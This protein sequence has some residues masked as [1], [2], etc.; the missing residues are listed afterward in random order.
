MALP[1][2]SLRTF[3]SARE[4]DEVHGRYAVPSGDEGIVGNAA[5][6]QADGLPSGLA[7]GSAFTTDGSGARGAARSRA[8]QD[9]D[10][11]GR[12]LQRA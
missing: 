5:T 3:V 12:V 6:R 10:V 2:R 7:S 11:E 8:P 9:S 1:V 4:T